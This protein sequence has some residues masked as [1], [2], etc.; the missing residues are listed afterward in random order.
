LKSKENRQVP[1]VPGI[2]QKNIFAH[3]L[4]M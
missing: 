1:L 2:E 3:L 4:Y